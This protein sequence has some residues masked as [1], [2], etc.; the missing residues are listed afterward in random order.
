[1][2]YQIGLKPCAAK[3]F[4]KLAQ[5]V[6]KGIKLAIDSLKENARPLGS[7]KLSHNQLY[8]IRLKNHS[9]YRIIYQIDDNSH[10]VLV[11]KIG[12]RDRIYHKI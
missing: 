7:K 5:D 3:D 9:K 1:M 10:E 2:P 12:L 4:S 6:Q 11:V 8:R